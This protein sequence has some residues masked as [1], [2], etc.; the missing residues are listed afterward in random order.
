MAVPKLSPAGVGTYS[1][2]NP[3]CAKFDAFT[4]GQQR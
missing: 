3:L 2:G 1:N 4:L